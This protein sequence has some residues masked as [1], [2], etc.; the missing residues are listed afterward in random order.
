MDDADL[1]WESIAKAVLRAP[2]AQIHGKGITVS[3][4]VVVELAINERLAPA[5]TAWHYEDACAPPRL[6]TAYPKLYTRRNGNY[7]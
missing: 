6:V 5:L 1:V 4:G 3:Y 7:G 2:I